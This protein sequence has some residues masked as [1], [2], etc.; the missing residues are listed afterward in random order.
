VEARRKNGEVFPI[1]LSVGE[2]RLG[3]RRI[4]TG[5][6]HDLTTRNRL[7][8]QLAQSQK[9]EA[10][11]R[12]AGGVAHDFNNVLQTVLAR[13]DAMRRRLPARSAL[14]AQVQEIQKAGRR[15]AALTRQLLAVSRTQVL[16]AR[17]VDLNVVLRDTADM[18]RRSLG[19]DVE[20][21]MDLEPDLA[22]VKVD[23][24][25]IVQVVLNLVV[26]ARDAMPRGGRL[27]VQ[28]R[29]ATPEDAPASGKAGVVLSVRD[30]G[31]GMDERTRARIF[32]PYFT[33]KGDKG[34][35]LGLSTVYG[36]VEQSGGSIRVESRLGEGS[37]FHVLL[38]RAEGRPVEE[39]VGPPRPAP[40]RRGARVLLVEDELAAR[41]ALEELLR[42]EGH[43]VLSA[44]NGLDAERIWRETRDPI[45]VVI[46]DTV[47][48]RMSGPELVERLRASHPDVRVIFMSGHTPETVLRHGGADP[49]TAFLQKPFEVDELLARVRD[50]L[51]GAASRKRRRT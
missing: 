26:N 28:T 8:E 7:Q 49:G 5:I 37:A 32:E 38:P 21:A 42:D 10:V 17:V 2:A 15:A 13:C 44:G 3:S 50:A 18:L 1:H 51:T 12:L 48:P 16:T 40:R 11:G 19:E 4:F 34:T 20:L 35:G 23:P 41:R 47:M 30:T 24:D 33:T 9:M 36:I 45:D 6:I 46:T 43:T 25:Q 39:V 14:R 22:P 31:A 29:K 27:H